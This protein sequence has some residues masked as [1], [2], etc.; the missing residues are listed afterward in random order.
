MDIILANTCAIGYGF[1][2]EK[3][4]EK[5]CQVLKIEPQCLIKSK[6]M[7]KVHGRAT[8]LITYAIYPILIV[9]IYTESLIS[10]FITKLENYHMIFS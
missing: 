1:I 5:A 4:A 9:A 7:Q 8:K 10:L 6:Q 3:F 2:D